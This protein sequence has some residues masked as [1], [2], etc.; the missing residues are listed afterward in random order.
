VE[1]FRN[2][3]AER[4]WFPRSAWEPVAQNTWYTWYTW[5]PRS[6]WEPEV[7]IPTQSVGPRTQ[8]VGTRRREERTRKT[9]ND[10]LKKAVDRLA[11]LAETSRDLVKQTDL[12]YKLA[13]RLIETCENDCDARSS[14]A[15]NH[16]DI[17]RARWRS[18]SARSP[19]SQLCKHASRR[20]FCRCA[21]WPRAS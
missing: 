1:S 9:S 15:W 20:C 13:A 5:F 10:E 18:A 3:V 12:L 21:R 6:A 19:V 2:S 8:S 4:D 11:K 17:T 16:R 7:R 14:D